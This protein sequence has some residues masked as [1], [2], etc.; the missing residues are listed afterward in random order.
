M[1][2]YGLRWVS[3]E[4]LVEAQKAL[5]QIGSDPRGIALMAGKAV[6]RALK[7]EAVPLKAAHILKQEMLAAGGDAAVHRDVITGNI[8]ATDIMLMG[9]RRQIEH[10]AKKLA[11]QPFGLK[12]LAI[13]LRQVLG[14]LELPEVRT[15]EC[16][17][18]SIP[19]GERTLVMGIVNITP[20]SFSDGGKFLKLED[21]INQAQLLI[22][23][24][25][26]ILDI[27][28]ESTRPGYRELS[29]EEEWQRL[30]PVLKE[31]CGQLPVPISLDTTKAKVAQKAL[32]LGVNIINDQWG[33]QRDPDMARIIGEYQ[34][35]VVVMHNQ[36]GTEYRH[37]MGDMLAFLRRSIELAEA[38]GLTGDQVIVDPGIGFGKTTAQN[39]AAMARLAE[40]KTLGRP[41]LLGI[42]RKS[43]IGNTLNLPVDQRLEGTIASNVIGVAAG[44]D[45]I[46]VHDVSANRRAVMM[47]DAILRGQRGQSYGGD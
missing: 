20:D 19:L 36:T 12:E 11:A 35:P 9:N 31:L 10:V 29:P 45:I 17:G 6:G 8:A 32:E 24:G 4:N 3:I 46:R 41:V 39:L 44:V 22:A 28:A 40:L 5:S 34:A 38:A 33:L 27:G 47:A 2:D 43:M 25:A 21:A 42:S 14:N 15:L 16:R 26:D 23:E 37:M 18:K 1:K 13:Q 30:E 7:L